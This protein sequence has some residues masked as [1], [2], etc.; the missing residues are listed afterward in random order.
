MN[1]LGKRTGGMVFL[2]K[3]KGAIS[4]QSAS[5]RIIGTIATVALVVLVAVPLV[6]LVL[7]AFRVEPPGIPSDFTLSN[8]AE[9][10]NSEAVRLLRNSL[11]IGLGTTVLGLLIGGTLAVIL[12]R[13]NVIG[14]KRLDGLVMIPAYM[15][16]FMGAI[17]WMIMFAP[18]IGYGTAVLRTLGLP[19]FNIY[20]FTGI[21]LVMGI[22]YAPIAYLY[23]RSMLAN[24]DPSLEEGARVLGASSFATLRRIVMPLALPAILSAM[25]LVL[26]AALGQ[27]GVP[28]VLGLRE[29]IDVI[30]TKIVQYA[31]NFPSEPTKAAALGV[32]LAIFA[33]IVMWVN[34]MVLNRRDYATIATRGG[35]VGGARSTARSLIPTIIAW[36]YV[37]FSAILPIFAL[38]IT[39]LMPYM[40]TKIDS[41]EFSL[42]NYVYV[43]TEFPMSIRA[44]T[45]S[46]VLALAAG[47][48]ATA[49]ALVLSHLRYR[50]RSVFRK[51][52][53]YLSS[54]SVSIPHSVIGLAFLW[55]WLIVPT[56][57]PMPFPIYGTTLII[58]MLYVAMFI[59]YASRATNSAILQVDKSFEEAG[60]V[61]GASWLAMLRRVS[62][63]LVRPGLL[64]AVIIVFYHAVRELP[65]S[66]LVVSPGNEVLATAIWSMYS[67]GQWVK[68]FALV[69]VNLLL[70]FVAVWI[71]R[72][73]GSQE[74]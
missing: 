70:V 34:N 48:I 71:M 69:N 10:L 62:L 40:T 46:L 3:A 29:G 1:T 41:V 43:L 51:P 7:A 18:D 63:P 56:L 49:I 20:S 33:V 23:I 65:A 58:L 42:D 55:T 59:P 25:L 61:L 24:I 12:L 31:T 36:I 53:D 57:V 35:R 8:F 21:I 39:S 67:E 45:N 50:T 54:I 60:R 74:N 2:G 28:G 22:Y 68:L 13:S 37:F 19:T 11:I 4:P 32:Q 72:R 64:T 27:F 5:Q 14:G 26:V 9:L 73:F 6:F 17:A 30:P 52:L 47:V 16:P 15:S 66:M 38:V 44:I